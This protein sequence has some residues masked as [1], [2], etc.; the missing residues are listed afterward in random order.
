MK[1]KLT[2]NQNKAI[3]SYPVSFYDNSNSA[4]ISDENTKAFIE[5]TIKTLNENPELNST[6]CSSGNVIVFAYRVHPED[7][8]GIHIVVSKN[9]EEIYIDNSVF[10]K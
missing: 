10:S 4:Q 9:Y 2:E 1:T 7:G 5:T 8:G 3:Q 6:H